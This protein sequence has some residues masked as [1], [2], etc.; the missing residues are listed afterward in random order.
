MDAEFMFCYFGVYFLVEF[1]VISE[2]CVHLFEFL[3]NEVAFLNDGFH[4]DAAA[5]EHLIDC[6]ELCELGVVDEFFELGDLVL[7]RDH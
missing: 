3:Y 1:A 5:H 7:K 4:G 6:H 2:D